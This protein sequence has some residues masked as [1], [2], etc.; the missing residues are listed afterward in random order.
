MM[1]IRDAKKS[2]FDVIAYLHPS[3]IWGVVWSGTHWKSP[4]KSEKALK[5]ETTQ[6]KISRSADSF[7]R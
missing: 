4:G 6:L 2:I 7:G 5:S 3:S 1:K